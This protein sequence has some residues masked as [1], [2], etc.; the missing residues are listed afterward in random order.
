[1]IGKGLEKIKKEAGSVEVRVAL[2]KFD[3]D[4]SFDS[5]HD[6]IKCLK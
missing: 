2:L 3:R 6:F 4:A 1:L 5:W